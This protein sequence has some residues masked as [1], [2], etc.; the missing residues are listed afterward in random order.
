VGTGDPK[1]PCSTN[2]NPSFS[3]GPVILRPRVTKK[4]FRKSFMN[5]RL[6]LLMMIEKN[7][8]SNM[9]ISDESSDG[10]F[11]KK[12]PKKTSSEPFL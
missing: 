11:A 10:L 5:K 1:D 8:Y 2:P 6:C 9:V 7:A 12:C 4:M 3:Q